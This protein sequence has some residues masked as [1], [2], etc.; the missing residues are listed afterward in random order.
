MIT[1]KKLRDRIKTK[2]SL[3]H[4][5]PA[6]RRL[7]WGALALVWAPFVALPA[8]AAVGPVAAAAI[9]DPLNIPP[10]LMGLAMVISSL[11]GATA[12]LMR[13]DRELSAAPDKPLPRP[14]IMS[15]SHM[16]GAW[17]AGMGAFIISRQYGFEVWP[18]LGFVLSA[19]F[20]NAKFLEAMLERFL[21]WRAGMPGA[22]GTGAST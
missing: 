21:P 14:W 16:A 3:S 15:S 20:A 7:I 13:I 11:A 6:L 1:M 18:T 19:S 22:P 2:P 9:E 8:I 4:T 12:L 17:L 10:V 5:A